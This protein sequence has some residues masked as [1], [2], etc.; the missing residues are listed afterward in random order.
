[1]IQ[2]D[3]SEG[4]HN[5]NQDEIQSAYFGHETFSIFTAC[6]Y[7]RPSETADVERVPIVI[8]NEA[9]NQSCIASFTCVSK[10]VDSIEERMPLLSSLQRMYIWYL[11]WW[12]FPVITLLFHICVA[13]SSTPR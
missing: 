1:M 3:Y 11:E 9:N 12:V 5:K 2:V 13:Y 6:E 4:Y 10:V 8:V 7:F